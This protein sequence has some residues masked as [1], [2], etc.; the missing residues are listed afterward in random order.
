[1]L[2]GERRRDVRRR[3]PLHKSPERKEE[4]GREEGQAGYSSTEAAQGYCHSQEAFP[5]T[6]E[7]RPRTDRYRVQ[8][9]CTGHQCT[10]PIMDWRNC[11]SGRPIHRPSRPS[12]IDK[13][14][15]HQ[16]PNQG[17]DTRHA[18]YF[19]EPE[20]TPREASHIQ[21]SGNTAQY[22]RHSAKSSSRNHNGPSKGHQSKS[23][24][25][26]TYDRVGSRDEDNRRDDECQDRVRRE[27]TI[28][29]PDRVS[30]NLLRPSLHPRPYQMLQMS[31]IR[32]Y[33]KNVSPATFNMRH[34]QRQAPDIR[35]RT[36]KE[37]RDRG[38]QVLQLQGKPRDSIQSLPSEKSQG[39]STTEGIPTQAGTQADTPASS[40]G[41]HPHDGRLPCSG[42]GSEPEVNTSEEGT[43]HQDI[44]HPVTSH[45]GTSH[46]CTSQTGII[47]PG[48]RHQQHKCSHNT[49]DVLRHQAEEVHRCSSPGTP[50]CGTHRGTNDCGTRT[51]H[52]RVPGDHRHV[53]QPVAG[54][55]TTDWQHPQG[56]QGH[57]ETHDRVYT[58]TTR[59]AN[60]NG[61]EGCHL[62][63]NGA[64]ALGCM[65]PIDVSSKC[66]YGSYR[67][68]HGQDRDDVHLDLATRPSSTIDSIPA[69][70]S[71]PTPGTL[72]HTPHTLVHNP[73]TQSTSP[74]VPGFP[75]IPGSSRDFRAIPTLR[76]KSSTLLACLLRILALREVK[77]SKLLL[78]FGQCIMKLL[79]LNIIF[80]TETNFENLNERKK[81]KDVC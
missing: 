71:P 60:V 29:D 19:A 42:T 50:D 36:K 63:V 2:G 33:V 59:E 3:D 6:Q 27:S 56:D 65:D 57:H 14:W 39:T 78:A 79:G 35:L 69:P 44:S 11:S 74:R 38:D 73:G 40:E 53:G 48:T 15:S 68:L 76:A 23:S 12:N 80:E 20:P 51:T 61:V 32:P 55:T 31:T 54:V 46:H 1:M 75:A 30:G 62:S 37:G 9:N 52:R 10:C 25:R 18:G 66:R 5:G 41:L 67:R 81:M 72:V 47:H 13:T 70:H 58:G 49:A 16:N 45:P 4:E 26:R 77:E 43:S 24:H 8:S 22:H 64:G 7:R 28:V 17:H 34:M 21:Y